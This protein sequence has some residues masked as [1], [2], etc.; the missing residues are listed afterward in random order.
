M[1][2]AI[3]YGI[4]FTGLIAHS[5][6]GQTLSLNEAMRLTL[7]AN[8]SLRAAELRVQ[9]RQAE[10]RAAVDLP[11]TDV[12]LMIGEYNSVNNDNNVT[13][14]QTLPFPVTLIRQVQF[15]RSVQYQSQ[16]EQ[17]L[18]R[19]QMLYRT[20]S[21]FYRLLYLK[22]LITV[23]HEADSIFRELARASD[24]R[25]RAGEGT[26]LEKTSAES[27]HR[28][29]QLQLLQVQTDYAT[30]LSRLS[31]LLNTTVGEVSG[32]LTEL[33]FN[34]TDTLLLDENPVWQNEN[35]RLATARTGTALEKARLWPDLRIGYFNQTLIGT[36]NINGT[37]VYFGRNTRFQGIEAGLTLPLWFVSPQQRIRAARLNEQAAKATLQQTEIEVK[38][39]WHQLLQQLKT[40]RAILDYYHQQ[41][42]P[43]SHLLL[44]QS[45][46]A[47]RT[48][49][50]SYTE[51]LLN[52][53]QALRIREDFLA[54]M[55]RWNQLVIETE[56]FSGQLYE[57]N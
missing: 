24:I 10:V 20:K 48:G 39:R 22:S 14:M 18:M 16:S 11:K 25:H 35:Y 51:T 12:N 36:Q 29:A 57:N 15:A 34:F 41:G 21:L 38:S 3:T 1:K 40:E 9:Q 52:A 6:L 30:E 49:E 23:R 5:A 46:K 50:L 47:F 31:E 56:Y 45:Q 42:I 28:E 27:R 43:A 17:M 37:D 2:T 26:L 13:I 44:Q 55:N 54:A 53:Q 33:A 19:H 32:D 7:T 8:A 4:I